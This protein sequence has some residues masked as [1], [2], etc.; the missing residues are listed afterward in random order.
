MKLVE[1]LWLDAA[2]GERQGWRAVA[3]MS[4][5]MAHECR[6]VGFLIHKSDD[7]VIV[8]P[9]LSGEQGDGEIV[10]PASWVVKILDLEVK[11]VRQTVLANEANNDE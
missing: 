5:G 10:I 4:S 7:R 2:G 11:P 3:G 8:C 1:V 6:S 9:H